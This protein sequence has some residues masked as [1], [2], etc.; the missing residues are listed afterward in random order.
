MAKGGESNDDPL[1]QTAKAPGGH[2]GKLNQVPSSGLI[3]PRHAELIW[4]SEDEGRG[5]PL[6]VRPNP[7]HSVFQSTALTTEFTVSGSLVCCEIN[8]LTAP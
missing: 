6:Q 3:G 5:V 2:T 4:Q 1:V 7:T 8:T